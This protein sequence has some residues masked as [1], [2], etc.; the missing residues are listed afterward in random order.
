MWNTR[1]RG[2]IAVDSL[3][4]VLDELVHSEDSSTSNV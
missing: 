1:V 2:L 4:A 3:M